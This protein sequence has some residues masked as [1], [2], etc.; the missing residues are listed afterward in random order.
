[1]AGGWKKFV[2]FLILGGSLAAC[3]KKA[4][5]GSSI[6]TPLPH[7]T[8]IA[9]LTLQQPGLQE[10]LQGAGLNT[11]DNC[12]QVVKLD[13][14]TRL[15]ELVSSFCAGTDLA[16][17]SVVRQL[18]I[19]TGSPSGIVQSDWLVDRTSGQPVGQMTESL[20]TATSATGSFELT[21]LCTGVFQFKGPTNRSSLT[22]NPF[23]LGCELKLSQSKYQDIVLHFGF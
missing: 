17:G 7:R 11:P 1:M 6:V 16:P 18:G 9:N 14:G 10:S 15:V 20:P 21:D 23:Y 8:W 5:V 4:L 19:V 12:A 3:Q 2:C 13:D 22:D